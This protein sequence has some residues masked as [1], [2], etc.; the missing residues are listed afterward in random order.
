[1][2]TDCRKLEYLMVNYCAHLEGEQLVRLSLCRKVSM[3][4]LVGRNK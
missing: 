2:Y 4:F 1:M 3:V